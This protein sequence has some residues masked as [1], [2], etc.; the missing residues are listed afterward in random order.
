MSTVYT[1]IVTAAACAGVGTFVHFLRDRIAK[2]GSHSLAN[3]LYS[4]GTVVAVD[5]ALIMAKT[6][7]A[8]QDA[9]EHRALSRTHETRRHTDPRRRASHVR[10][11]SATGRKHRP[12]AV[13]RRLRRTWTRT[14]VAQRM[15]S[16]GDLQR[17]DS[18]STTRA[19]TRRSPYPPHDTAPALSRVIPLG[20]V[21]FGYARPRFGFNFWPG[22][23]VLSVL[24]G[25]GSRPG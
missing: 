16:A 3:R 24:L 5:G 20:V 2:P 17:T 11:R 14:A 19:T 9:Q 10:H 13:V 22:V 18:P 1:M 7:E 12:R 6:K 15:A 25:R 23:G 4:V 8:E 21:V